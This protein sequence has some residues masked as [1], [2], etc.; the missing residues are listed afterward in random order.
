MKKNVAA[1]RLAMCTA[2]GLAV[3]GEMMTAEVPPVDRQT[4]RLVRKHRGR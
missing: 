1:V 4:R 2:V 3:M